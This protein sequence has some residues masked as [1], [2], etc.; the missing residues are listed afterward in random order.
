MARSE[1]VC[2]I[3][4]VKHASLTVRSW[5]CLMLQGDK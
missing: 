5:L 1:Y 2:V 4:M 3:R